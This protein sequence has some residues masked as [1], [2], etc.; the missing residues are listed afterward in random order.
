MLQHQYDNLYR[1]YT[2]LE[3]NKSRVEMRADALEAEKEEVYQDLEQTREETEGLLARVE[4][5]EANLRENQARAQE[6]LER[7]KQEFANAEMDHATASAQSEEQ[8]EELEAKVRSMQMYQSDRDAAD[9]Q[10][11]EELA[12]VRLS[13][14]ALET[15][16]NKW[17]MADEEHQRVIEA[18]EKSRNEL[19]GKCAGLLAD[20]EALR[21]AMAGDQETHDANMLRVEQEALEE[22]NALREQHS[23]DVDR[24]NHQ[25]QEQ[26]D[27]LTARLASA[28]LESKQVQADLEAQLDKRE[29][30]LS[31]YHKKVS[32]IP[33]LVDQPLAN[34]DVDRAPERSLHRQG[35]PDRRG[36]CYALEP[37]GRNG[38]G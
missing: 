5:L 34:I 6:E 2:G 10:L 1:A 15:E 26:L 23:K 35:R 7:L 16:M 11:R 25:K 8:I 38:L 24:M 31:D 4:E 18:V 29:K 9:G 28:Q 3:D 19:E 36:Q 37:H 30:K 17:H 20:L 22:Q 14:D 32:R 33:Q 27:N 21:Q 12:A 13:K